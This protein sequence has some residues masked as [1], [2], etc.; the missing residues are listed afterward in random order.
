MREQEV[1]A[2][3]HSSDYFT[4]AV[5][6]RGDIS[7]EPV[8]G[9][10]IEEHVVTDLDLRNDENRPG[11]TSSAAAEEHQDVSSKNTIDEMADA[12][13]G[14]NDVG[15]WSLWP[16]SVPEKMRE[17]WLKFETGSF[18]Y[19]DEKSFL[20]HDVP[21]HIKDRNLSRKCTTSLIRCQNHNGEVVDRS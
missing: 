4:V 14:G 18:W 5:K 17:Y 11:L 19:F 20:K 10:K 7:A 15:L 2:K 8:R 9:Q 1:A 6:S 21:Q 3:N 16:V 12:I 13:T